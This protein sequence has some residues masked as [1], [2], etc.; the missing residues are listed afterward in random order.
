MTPQAAR[1]I[2]EQVL[3]LLVLLALLAGFGYL[4]V[5][6]GHWRRSTFVMGC[7]LLLAG[8]FRALV[9]QRRVG[10]LAVRAR[11]VDTV[12]YLVLGGVVLAV[13]LRLHN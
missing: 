4:V 1:W 11:W 5:G 8:M 12:V 9:P 3:F 2:R 13:D 10:L 6:P 7:A